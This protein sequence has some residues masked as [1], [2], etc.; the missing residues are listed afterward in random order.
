M[1]HLAQQLA[2]GLLQLLGRGARSSVRVG[3]L[4]SLGFQLLLEAGQ[5]VP[6]P[7]QV[8]LQPAPGQGRCSLMRMVFK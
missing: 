6:L 3:A 7:P 2:L 5:G 4:L 1:A 8:I